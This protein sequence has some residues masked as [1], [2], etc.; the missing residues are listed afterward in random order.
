MNIVIS[1]GHGKFVRGASGVLDEVDEARRV[2]DQ[3]A[4]RLRELGA[5]VAVFHDNTSQSQN[6][7]LN[8]IVN[9]HNAQPAH[10]VD[11]SVHFNAYVETDDPMGTEC[12]YVSQAQLADNLSTGIAKAGN[13]IDRGPKKRTDLF[14]LNNTN[15]P[16]VLIEVCFVDSK[17]DAEDYE[18]NFAGICQSIAWS[19]FAFAGG[20]KPVPA[21]EPQALLHV[22]GKT[23][24]FGGPDDMGV[25][26]DE[27]LAFFYEYDDA[28]H[29]FLEQQ[30][31]GTSG[32]ARRLNVER[33]YVA[34]RWDYDVTPK[35]MLQQPYPALVRSPD[36]GKQFLAWPADWGPHEDTGR[37]ADISPSLM[38]RLGISTDDVVEVIYPAPI[39]RLQHKRAASKNKNEKTI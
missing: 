22:T 27:G 9:F 28:P 2:V 7:N 16:A 10:D 13:L 19:L 29:L 38:D 15:E 26:A 20:K 30:P 14:F 35:D 11:V 6:E 5:G 33:S 8:A 37:V 3:V 12:L 4:V 21:S 25:D 39:E 34:C 1:S 31:P 32:L 36:T 24:Y 23:S 18:D 17:A